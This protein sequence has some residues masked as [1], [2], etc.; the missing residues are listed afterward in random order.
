M[1]KISHL[2]MARKMVVLIAITKSLKNY[3]R[4]VYFFTNAA[5]PA[6]LVKKCLLVFSNIFNYFWDNFHVSAYIFKIV[7]FQNMRYPCATIIYLNILQPVRRSL[8]VI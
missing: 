5:G 8:S 6:A 7:N 4:V 3:R 2:E 1:F